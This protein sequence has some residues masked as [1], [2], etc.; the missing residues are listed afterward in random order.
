MVKRIA[1][2]T[3]GNQF[4]HLAGSDGTLQIPPWQGPDTWELFTKTKTADGKVTLEAANSTAANRMY[5]SAENG[6]GGLVLARRSPAGA[7]EKFEEVDKGSGKIAL[8]TANGNFLCAEARGGDL[9]LANKSAAGEWETFEVVAGT[10][11]KIALKAAN[12]QYVR[13][14]GGGGGRVLVNRDN[15]EAETFV[16]DETSYPGRVTLRAANGK[17]LCA[18]K[19]SGDKV[20]ANRDGVGGDWEKF[21]PKPGVGDTLAL[22][23]NP[24]DKWV[25]T[26]NGGGAGLLATGN[27]AKEWETFVRTP[28]YD[29]PRPGKLLVYYGWPSL[30]NGANGNKTAA[31]QTFSQY[32]Y[33]VLGAGLEQTTHG[34]NAATKEIISNIRWNTAGATKVF[35]YLALGSTKRADGTRS[36]LTLDDIKTRAGLWKSIGVDGIFLDEFG[37]D[38]YKDNET[39]PG[40]A[41]ECRK[42]QN[43]AV[44][45]VH[46]VGLTVI[47]N[48]WKPDD[49]WD[50]AG[51]LDASTLLPTDFYFSESYLIKK[52]A[53][54][55][56][57]EWRDKAEKLR[58]YQAIHDFRIL[59]VSTPENDVLKAD[60]TR[61]E[62]TRF[63]A[64]MFTYA[65]H[66]A[67]LYGHEAFGWGERW[68]SASGLDEN[69]ADYHTRPSV[70]PSY[71]TGPITGNYQR[72][73]NT[74]TVSFNPMAHTASFG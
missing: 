16:L 6:G 33:V 10:D 8:K 59:S 50:T 11:G 35:G 12:G 22:Q 62:G 61:D 45:R 21:T 24:G 39:T 41:A 43:G 23:A 3:N 4:V 34:D 49:V 55:D 69:K 15:R 70:T 72:Q 32:E 25:Q 60:G 53:Y 14:E 47:A 28:W 46:G 18:E 67:M 9:L 40:P 29:R 65:W 54:Q 1:L 38:Y 42:R 74:G 17:Y 64:G 66:G 31:G 73:T 63:D 37:M 44:D 68:F 48:A 57:T 56:A 51:G 2:R 20:L 52:G 30:I 13:A 71:F 26:A 5:L 7:W 27:D 58:S 36:G 19:G